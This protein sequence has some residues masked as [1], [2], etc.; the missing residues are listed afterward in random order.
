MEEGT[1]DVLLQNEEGVYS[2]LVRAQALEMGKDEY[3]EEVQEGEMAQ[4]QKEETN[5]AKEKDSTLDEMVESEWKERGVMRSFGLLV[6]EQ[7]KR[8]FLYAVT[9][10]G[11]AGAG[12]KSATWIKI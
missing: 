4:L 6:Y 12:G 3:E 5:K 7:R 2:S 11:C 1:H 8:W 9:L 10:T